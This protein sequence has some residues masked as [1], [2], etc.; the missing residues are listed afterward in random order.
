M[1][2][3]CILL[4]YAAAAQTRGASQFQITK[5]TKNLISAPQFTYTGAEQYQTNQ[6]DR[7]L[8]VEVEFSAAPEFTN[9]LTFKYYI[10]FN[11]KLLTGEVSHTNIAAGTSNR[12]VMYV[13]PRTLARFGGNRP[14]TVSSFQNIAVQIEQQGVVKDELS[15]VR[16]PAHWFAT[17]PQVSGFVVNKNETP[18][19]PLYWGRYEQIKGPTR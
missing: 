9:E 13:S 7:W 18:F 4:P 5:I 6:R 15:L 10:L 19:A 1:L 3:V 17:M 12:S 14:V 8:E 11:G 16:A 2:C